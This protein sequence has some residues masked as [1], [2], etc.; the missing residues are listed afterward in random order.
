MNQMHKPVYTYRDILYKLPSLR[1]Q[2]LLWV[3]CRKHNEFSNLNSTYQKLLK[4]WLK[5]QLIVLFCHH[6]NLQFLSLIMS[7]SSCRWDHCRGQIWVFIQDGEIFMRWRFKSI[8]GVW[9]LFDFYFLS[10]AL[11]LGDGP[12][13]DKWFS[14]IVIGEVAEEEYE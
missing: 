13:G 12:D 2:M 6:Q 3:S 5:K 8:K 11:R 10:H 14:V 9:T 7:N 4:Q 1:S